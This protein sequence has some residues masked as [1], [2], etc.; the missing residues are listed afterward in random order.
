MAKFI[1]DSSCDLLEM[2]G[3]LFESIPLVIYTDETSYTDDKDIDIHGMLDELSK[4]KGRSYT[5][6]P[7][8][9]AWMSAFEGSDEIYVVTMT[10]ELSGTYNSA[11]VA[12]DMYLQE[13]PEV[14][15]HIFDTLSTGPEMRLL[16]EKLVE[17]DR[18]GM[19]F[20]E[21]CKA[22]EEYLKK[23]R[24]FFS[25]QSL[26][27]LAQN[28]R[29]N[30]VLA[31]AIGALGISVIGTASA[32]GTIEA[33]GKCRGDKKVISTFLS[34][35]KSA[36]FESGKVRIG[37]IENEKLA[38]RLCQI[39]LEQYPQADVEVFPARGLC[40]YY[41]ERGCIMLGCEGN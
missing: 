24:L 30:K 41:G 17:L 8:T 35:M 31:S 19:V 2:Q 37:Q 25:F 28:G 13:H 33:V 20:E 40:S 32:K 7:G 10:S 39:I 6:C 12:K 1:G 9:E 11:V 15:I 14:K 5:A 16:L 3:V 26:H 34:Q 27:N 36:G 18:S 21:V 23:T 38:G 22:G 4:Y 29:V